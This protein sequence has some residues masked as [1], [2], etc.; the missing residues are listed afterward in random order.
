M[1][2]LLIDLVFYLDGNFTEY[3]CVCFKNQVM[4]NCEFGRVNE[5]VHW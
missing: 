5:W 2:I 4:K 1:G 3:V